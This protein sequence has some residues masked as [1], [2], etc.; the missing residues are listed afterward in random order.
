[1]LKEEALYTVVAEDE[2]YSFKTAEDFYDFMSEKNS[3]LTIDRI[4]KNDN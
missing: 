4:E 2:T 3:E 1:M